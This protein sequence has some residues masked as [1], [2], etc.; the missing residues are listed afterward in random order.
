MNFVLHAKTSKSYLLSSYLLCVSGV[1]KKMSDTFGLK[2]K[3]KL[4]HIVTSLR[5]GLIEY[6]ETTRPLMTSPFIGLAPE[7]ADGIKNL[8]FH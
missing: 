2:N 1:Y 6:V 4:E 3:D 5:R 8:G 7:S